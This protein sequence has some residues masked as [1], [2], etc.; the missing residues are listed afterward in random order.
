MT[1]TF[2]LVFTVSILLGILLL[3]MIFRNPKL[4][5]K[6]MI[7]IELFFTGNKLKRVP[8]F[9]EYPAHNMADLKVASWILNPKIIGLEDTVTI[10]AT[11][12]NIGT[13]D[14]KPSTLV[15]YIDGKE[16]AHQSIGTLQ[17]NDKQ[18]IRIA[19]EPSSPGKHQI[20][21]ELEPS[22]FDLSVDNNI[23]SDVIRVSGEESPLPEIIFEEI[24][25]E[26]LDL[27]VGES[28]TIPI[29]ITNPSFAEI[30]NIPLIF[31]LDHELLSSE[32][33][34]YLP[35]GRNQ[36]FEIHWSKVT[37]GEH[38]LLV[39]AELGDGFDFPVD[40]MVK[41]WSIGIPDRTVLNNALLKH[42]WVSIGPSLIQDYNIA[43]RIDSFA[44]H[45]TNPQIMYAGA[46]SG[47][48]T[49]SLWKTV[50][51]G[52]DWYPLTDKIFPPTRKISAIA[53]D[54][55]D[56]D[57]VYYA[58][59][60][61]YYKDGNGIFKS[62]DGGVYW[63][64]FASSS[65]V[66]GACKISISYPSSSEIVIIAGTDAGVLR[67]RS[68]NPNATTSE[69]DEWDVIKTGRIMDMAVHP[70]NPS[71]IYVCVYGEGIFRTKNAE[72]AIDDSDW[73]EL[74]TGLPDLKTNSRKVNV[75]ILDVNPS[76]L[77]AAVTKP[78][79]NEGKL[80]LYKSSDEGGTWEPVDYG[81]FSNGN[82]FLRVS[83]DGILFY[84]NVDY[85]KY[86]TNS[87]IETKITGIH[88][89]MKMME[90]DPFD[91]DYYYLSNDGGIWRGKVTD[92]SGVHRNNNLRTIQFYDFDASS[93]NSKL[94]LGGTQDSGTILYEGSNVWRMVRE[95]DGLYSLISPVNDSVWYSQNQ[96]LRDTARSIN[97]GKS[98][99]GVDASDTILP[100][101][102][103]MSGEKAY[104][105]AHPKNYD[106]VLSVGEVVFGSDDGGQFWKKKG[107][108][109][110]MV[111]GHV[112]RILIQNTTMDWFVGTSKGQL[113]KTNNG[114]VS[115]TMIDEHVNN[116]PVK[117]MAFA[118]TDYRVLY[119][120]YSDSDPT[121]Y[122][123]IRRL[124]LV[125]QGNWQG[126]SISGSIDGFFSRG[127]PNLKIYVISGDGHRSDL[128]YIGTNQG[129][130]LWDQALPMNNQWQAYNDG[131]P[132]TIVTDLLVD[133][134]S[135]ELRAATFGRGAWTVVT[136]P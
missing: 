64:Q 15:V 6:L 75:D 27:R 21:F 110:P 12:E 92:S 122:W 89:D 47:F 115:W 116:A 23:L 111:K 41:S 8:F 127:L 70:T 101:G 99:R 77:Y 114:G 103:D 135:K 65:I 97:E 46:G 42:K 20:R 72:D 109:G 3:I 31:Y 63:D 91:S 44:F 56:P 45:P 59:G 62:I 50:N 37:H 24:D 96:F 76:T 18:D 19:W 87:G 121:G 78:P 117:S 16:I 5:A 26:K 58:T 93:T 25:Y 126:T 108:K 129:V 17:V 11:V 34:E 40:K 29:T 86:N 73:T 120:A 67:Y 74:V 119:V 84:G 52:L 61:P 133:P 80:G 7:R 88:F 104:I 131:F 14:A 128:A 28:C 53:V 125:P 33:I 36:R 85:F 81:T 22:G 83:N 71:I 9:E 102:N 100:R 136:G 54:P 69:P 132:N 35:P 98:W 1:F 48:S 55:N 2:S 130:Y 60:S 79:S 10:T 39:E 112:T 106:R 94:M 134:S 51:A 13:G 32:I 113:W 90:F 105:I 43:G 68:N 124:E 123:R 38:I 30:R 49:G 66:K 4:R 118:P 82:A 107:P 57:T 95:G